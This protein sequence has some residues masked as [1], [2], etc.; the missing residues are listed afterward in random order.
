M[1]TVK[2]AISLPEDVYM[3]AQREAERQ[4]VSR[5]RLFSKAIDDYLIRLENAEMIKAIDEA[6][7]DGLDPD[8]TEFLQAAS[9]HIAELTEGEYE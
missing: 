3:R 7:A 5:S 6:Y 8:E 9:R 1:A 2:T 4:N